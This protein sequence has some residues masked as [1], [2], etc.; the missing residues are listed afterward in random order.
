VRSRSLLPVL[1][2]VQARDDSQATEVDLGPGF[3]SRLLLYRDL[4]ATWQYRLP[5]TAET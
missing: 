1:I 4:I 2:E 5:L 3:K